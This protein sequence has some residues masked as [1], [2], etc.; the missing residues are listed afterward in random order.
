MAAP[1]GGRE[2]IGCFGLTEPDHGSDPGGCRR[3]PSAM[4]LTGCFR[5]KMWITNG[6]VADIRRG[7]GRHRDGIRGSSFPRDGWFSRRAT[8]T[9]SCRCARP[10]PQSCTWTRS[11]CRRRRIAR[12]LRTQRSAVLPDGSPVRHRLGVTGAA[13]NWLESAIEYACT[14]EQF[15]SDRGLSADAGQAEL[16]GG[17]PV[18]SQL[19]GCTWAAQGGRLAQPGPGQHRQDDQR[20]I[21]LDIARQART[22]LGPAA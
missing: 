6:S 9:R 4:D 7:V 18:P 16:D 11:G 21:G 14:R 2:A 13:R 20:E 3:S 22:V 15:G 12:R 10:S 5:Y 17:R 8:S 19:L 1:D